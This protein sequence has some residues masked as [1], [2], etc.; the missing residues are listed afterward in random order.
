MSIIG[1]SAWLSG[2]YGGFSVLPIFL[3]KNIL[4]LQHSGFSVV[5]RHVAM[6]VVFSGKSVAHSG[7]FVVS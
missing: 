4:Y 3:Y 1:Y 7:H 6:F 5:M 2:F